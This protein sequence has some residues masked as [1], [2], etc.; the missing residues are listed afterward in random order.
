MDSLA[1][2][3]QIQK[4]L[5]KNAHK[6]DSP[7]VPGVK[8]SSTAP[9]KP[10]G[11]TEVKSE[12]YLFP[13][14]LPA[15]RH[16]TQE[17]LENHRLNNDL[18]GEV[19]DWRDPA[20]MF[21]A[22]VDDITPYRWQYEEM[23]RL[24]GYNGKEKVQP[25]PALP[26]KYLMAAANG[27]GKDQLIIAS[28]AVWY[29]CTGK[30]SRVVGTSASDRQVKQQTDP[31][32]RWLATLHNK[33][34]GR[35]Y[36]RSVQKYHA[37]PEIGSR[38]E[39]YVTNNEGAAE[40]Y[41]PDPGGRMGLFINEAKSVGTEAYRAL[42]RCS[43][44][45]TWIEISSPGRTVGRFYEK[46]MDCTVEYP[47][48][49]ELGKYYKRT[50]T[51]FDCPHLTEAQRIAILDEGGGGET[52]ALYESSWLAKFSSIHED[53]IIHQYMLDNAAGAT[54]IAGK[55]RIGLDIGSTGDPSAIYLLRGNKIV[56][57]EEFSQP[58][59]IKQTDYIMSILERYD[60]LDAEGNGDHNGLGQGVIDG[61]RSRGVNIRGI[62]NQA[63][64]MDSSRYLNLGAETW[65][66][67]KDLIVNKILHIPEKYGQLRS[68]LTSRYYAVRGNGKYALE[69]KKLHKKRTEGKSP[70]RADAFVL[71]FAGTTV[72]KFM[73]ESAQPQQSRIVDPRNYCRP[74]SSM[75]TYKALESSK[76]K[77]SAW[78]I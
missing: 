25:T 28:W 45:D 55:K 32:I 30:R 77:V 21:L 24:A 39:L 23:R 34:L 50:I 74:P 59:L 15:D 36:F 66:S 71:A 43:G 64:A 6:K 53:V 19:M 58:D 7:A 9:P 20:E 14:R 4:L 47:M 54:E 16:L 63:A 70:N 42:T 69:S 61:L 11:P 8:S 72:A 35:Q 38:I 48:P 44:Y 31:W 2:L 76:Q 65:F 12:P 1:K 18:D 68:E 22:L 10:P 51:G 56:Y 33:Y 26:I 3:K 46:W 40:G 57:E 62:Y 78:T 49:L 67:L 27:S 73:Q 41:H 29:A 75:E 52:N 13:T 37:V 60:F 5:D 17:H